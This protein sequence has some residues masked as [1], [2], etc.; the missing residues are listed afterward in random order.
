MRP[1]S[2]S[3]HTLLLRLLSRSSGYSR[4]SRVTE[5]V[6]HDLLRACVDIGEGRRQEPAL[7]SNLR[8]AC[9][10]SARSSHPIFPLRRQEPALLGQQFI[11]PL[12]TDDAWCAR[13]SSEEEVPSEEHPPLLCARPRRLT[14]RRLPHRAPLQVRAAGAGGRPFLQNEIEGEARAA[15]PLRGA[16][17]PA[18]RRGAAVEGGRRLRLRLACQCEVRVKCT[19]FDTRFARGLLY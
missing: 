18:A 17:Q 3:S 12:R 19:H 16:L 14:A 15:R 7:P 11:P 6:A 5:A 10:R 1:Y 2:A 8:V 13:R 9:L 4:D